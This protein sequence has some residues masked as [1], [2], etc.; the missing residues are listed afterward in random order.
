MLGWMMVFALVSI[1]AAVTDTVAGSAA[2]LISMKAATLLFAVLFLA[3][4]L[5]SVVRGRV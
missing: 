1:S 5:T 2:T 3:C 4:F